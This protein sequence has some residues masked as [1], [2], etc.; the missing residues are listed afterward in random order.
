[1]YNTRLK[2]YLQ[3]NSEAFNLAAIIEDGK[4][5]IQNHCSTFTFHT[6]VEQIT[7]HGVDEAPES[8]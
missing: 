1:M 3:C 2:M 8:C 6:L 4:G 5:C 7:L